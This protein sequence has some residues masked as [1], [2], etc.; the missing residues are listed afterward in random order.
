MS[1]YT[2]QALPLFDDD[3]YKAVSY[4]SN[5]LH[6]PQAANNL[7]DGISS[8]INKRSENPLSFEP[9]FFPTIDEPY[10][11]IYVGNY[12]I[13]YVVNGACMELHRFLYNARDTDLI[14]SNES[15]ASES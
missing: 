4:I 10:Y 12:V 8:A 15:T 13:Y 9:C 14:F 7:I 1:K 5:E 2:V 3:V 11:R 6:N